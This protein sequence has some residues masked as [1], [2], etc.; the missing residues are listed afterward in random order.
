MEGVLYPSPA[1]PKVD[2]G[3]HPQ[4]LKQIA[5]M[6]RASLSCEDLRVSLALCL[7]CQS[8]D[9]DLRTTQ[10]SRDLGKSPVQDLLRVGPA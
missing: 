4:T 8:P 3:K 1:G 9:L 7:G 6:I 2:D 5:I 10:V